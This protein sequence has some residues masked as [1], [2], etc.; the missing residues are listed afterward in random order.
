MNRDKIEI[1]RTRIGALEASLAAEKVRQ[2]KAKAKL[3]ARE[4]SLVGE[5]LVRFAADSEEFHR[6]LKAMLAAAITVADEPARKFLTGRG[7]LRG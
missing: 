5:A 3:Q 2:Q 7:W 6:T 1:L 4:F